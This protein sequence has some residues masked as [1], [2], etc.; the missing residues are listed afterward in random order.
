MTPPKLVPCKKGT[1]VSDKLCDASERKLQSSKAI[2]IEAEIKQICGARYDCQEKYITNVVGEKWNRSPW[3]IIY[4][5]HELD[6][7]SGA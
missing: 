4:E 6:E 7:G 3:E 5:T 2:R 1:H